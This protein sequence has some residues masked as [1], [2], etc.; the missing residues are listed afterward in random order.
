MGAVPIYVVW[1]RVGFV[2]AGA[3]LLAACGGGGESGVDWSQVPS[4]QHVAISDAVKAGDCARM[5]TMFD[6]S[7]RSDVLEYLDKHMREAGCYK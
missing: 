5:Q 3:L 7:K 1:M 6:G 4:N 2:L